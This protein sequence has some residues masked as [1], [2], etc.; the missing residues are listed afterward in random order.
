MIVSTLIDMAT[1]VWEVISHRKRRSLDWEV[2][3]GQEALMAEDR[4]AVATGGCQCGAVRYALYAAPEGSVCHCRMCQKAVGGPFAAL[5]KIDKAD[6]VWTR[7]QPASFLSSSAAA[8]DFC[9]ACGTPLTFRYLDAAHMEVTLG[10]LDDPAA[11]PALANFGIESRLPWIADLVPGRL[12]DKTT[13]QIA[14]RTIVNR[15]H[16]DHDTQADWKPL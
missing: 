5:A 1:L 13:A 16:P 4:R 3:S 2:F 9:A 15:Q 8:R 12:P 7:G 10:S 14:K 11:V 6:I